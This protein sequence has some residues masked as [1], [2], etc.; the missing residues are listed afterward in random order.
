MANLKG[1]NV[2]RFV[3][4]I[5]KDVATSAYEGGGSGGGSNAPSYWDNCNTV[6]EW[7]NNELNKIYARDKEAIDEGL[8]Q[9]GMA[10]DWYKTFASYNPETG[11]YDEEAVLKDFV[12]IFSKEAL[13]KFIPLNTPIK[14]IEEYVG[15][16]FDIYLTPYNLENKV[17][18]NLGINLYASFFGNGEINGSFHV[19]GV[20]YFTMTI[21]F[22]EDTTLQDFLDEL[23]LHRSTNPFNIGDGLDW[24]RSTLTANGKKFEPKRYW[25]GSHPKQETTFLLSAAPF[26]KAYTC[27]WN[28]YNPK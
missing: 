23:L 3:E 15:S 26:L 14:D 5:S 16:N 27:R 9:P 2:K 25:P 22:S 28:I 10:I 7:E 21:S 1:E 8:S 17:K 24:L 4:N 20:C 18:T 11:E 19:F 12:T 6:D 13:S